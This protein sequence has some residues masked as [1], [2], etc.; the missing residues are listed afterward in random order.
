V[1]EN[2][3]GEIF[4][5]GGGERAAGE[6]GVPFLGSVELDPNVRIGGDAGSPIVV[7]WPD[8]AAAKSL[9]KLARLVA[10]KLNSVTP[11][12]GPELKII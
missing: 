11:D 5:R 3:S 9:R 12:A 8:S 10:L 6:L 4:G 7:E 1:I 2:M